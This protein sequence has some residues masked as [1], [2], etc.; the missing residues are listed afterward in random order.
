MAFNNIALI[1]GIINIPYNV[2]KYWLIL[3]SLKEIKPLS[4]NAKEHNAKNKRKF[5]PQINETIFALRLQK[6]LLIQH[7]KAMRNEIQSKII[8]A[9]F[10]G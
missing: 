8:R 9:F 1:Y 5:K 6:I 3:Q 2:M 4:E 10:F 7:F